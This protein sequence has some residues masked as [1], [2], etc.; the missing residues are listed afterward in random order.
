MI[1][2]TIAHYRVTA[3]L[4]AGGMGEVYRATDSKLG[5]D[6]AL[7]VLPEAFSQDNLRMQRFQREAQVL[8]SLNHPHIAAIYGLEHQDRI[9]ALAMELVEGP[10]LAER[11][12][13]GAIP[14][15]DALPIARQIAEAL[16][17]AHEKG[18]IHRDLKPANIKLTPDGKVKVLD[19]GLAKALEGGTA[20]MDASNSPTISMAATKMGVILGTAAYMSPEQAKGKAVDRRTDIWSFGVVLFEMLT[21]HQTFSGETSTDIMAAVVRA[22]PDWTILPAGVPQRIRKLLQRCL[23]K[24][25]KRRLRDIGDARL[26]LEEGSAEPIAE[27]AATKPATRR[28]H[29]GLVLP[30]VLAAALGG[31]LLL[32]QW[33]KPEPAPGVSRFTLTIPADLNQG[34]P[35]S[36]SPDGRTIAFVAD[37]FGLSQLYIR[38][39]D[40]IDSQPVRGAVLVRSNFFSADGKWIGFTT[41][42]RKI[43]KVSV[44]DGTLLTLGDAPL[45]NSGSWGLDGKIVLATTGAGL[46]EIS[47]SGGSSRPL[48]TIDPNKGEAG[49]VWPTIL[50]KGN[51]V[52]FTRWPRDGSEGTIEALVFKTGQRKVVL[53]DGSCTT[54]SPTGHLLFLRGGALM[55]APFDADRVEVTGPVV[56]VLD[57][58]SFGADGGLKLA[59]S[60]TGVLVYV[61]KRRARL[62]WVDQDGKEKVLTESSR[63]F[64]SARLSPD[65]RRLAITDSGQIWFMDLAR[66]SYSRFALPASGS[67][68]PAWSPNGERIAYTSGID[69]VWQRSDGSGSPE[70]LVSDPPVWKAALSF[71]PDGSALAFLALNPKTSSDIYILN[72]NGKREIRPFLNGPAFEGAGQFSPNGRYMAYVSDETGQREIYVTSYPNPGSKWQVST[73]GGTHPLWSGD[74]RRL[75]YRIGDRM[76]VADIAEAGGF[77]ASKPRLLFTGDYIYSMN[78]TI[79]NYSVTRDGKRFLMIRDETTVRGGIQIVQNWFE[80]LRRKTSSAAK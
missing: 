8:A 30:W 68:Y 59:L 19:F 42:D 43:K 18:V 57:E 45:S 14:L 21:G 79:P 69:I 35:F 65:E 40:Q 39:L 58:V 73:D 62:V 74:G 64:S 78:A 41:A 56:K 12:A 50:P 15:E 36:I 49:H 31:L 6:V 34:H 28:W 2:Q 63:S 1:G 72:L 80:E 33:N 48:T 53:Q 23:V 7:K 55:A 47:A 67:P 22:E 70:V 29:W 11:I 26:E 38:R 61:T 71:S 4:G 17:Y 54:Y 13:A 5:R 10:T 24:D 16:E 76:M 52:L 27:F 32:T 66:D 75:Y 37:E 51:A 9:Q 20:Q 60:D 44:A 25:E 77:S 46:Q 3:K